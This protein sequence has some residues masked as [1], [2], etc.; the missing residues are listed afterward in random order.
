MYRRVCSVLI[1]KVFQ[2][3][4]SKKYWSDSTYSIYNTTNSLHCRVVTGGNAGTV[5][6]GGGPTDSD[7]TD[8]ITVVTAS[9]H[10]F[11]SQSCGGIVRYE[12]AVGVSAEGI[13]RESLI[14]FT[15][16]GIFDDG[17]GSGHA[18]LPVAG[19]KDVNHRL[20]TTVRGITGCG[21]ILESTSNGF[22]I[23]TS[24]PSLEVI[25]TGSQAI[26]R[27]QYSTNTH[28][29]YQSVDLY[30]SIWSAHDLQSGVPGDVMV[31]I[32]TFPGGSDISS[33]I[34]VPDDYIR[35]RITTREEGTP[36]YVTVTA[37]NGA[38]VESTAISEPITLDTSP[39][40]IGEVSPNLIF[41][42]VHYK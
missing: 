12:W 37:T 18:Q 30:S 15:S 8:E 3:C 16:K 5:L 39:P 4:S 24:P 1:K 27:A 25:G 33:N 38:R 11:S 6:D 20:Y 21:N 32:G 31:K 23:D 26:E 42:T 28:E 41:Q 29:S 19:L 35:T 17:D 14:Q 34:T 9:F 22:I 10:S 36:T 40:F 13:E 7:F 2:C